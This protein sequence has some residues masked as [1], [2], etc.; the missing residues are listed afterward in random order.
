MARNIFETLTVLVVDDSS[1]MRHLMLGLLRALGVGEVVL[2]NDGED[3]WAKFIT[4]KPDV[5]IT[6]AAM[7]PTDGFALAKRLR[8]NDA[9]ACNRVPIIMISAHTEISA[10]KKARDAGITEF[11]CKPLVPRTLYER[12]IAVINR[13]QEAALVADV[14]AAPVAY[15]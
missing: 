14:P 15:L 13:K 8:E 11:V 6:D 3:A 12:L 10:I 7:A 2:A 9:P 5:V 4:H 1:H